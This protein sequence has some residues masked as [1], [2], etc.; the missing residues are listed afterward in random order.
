MRVQQTMRG[1]IVNE[2]RLSD[3]ARYHDVSTDAAAAMAVKGG[4]A[5]VAPRSIIP[6]L[7]GGAIDVGAAYFFWSKGWKKLSVIWAVGGAIG[8]A[9]RAKE[10]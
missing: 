3:L 9:L 4:G 10:G 8:L 6:L 1:L 5:T 2:G 7:V